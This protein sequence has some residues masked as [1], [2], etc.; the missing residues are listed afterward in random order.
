[1]LAAYWFGSTKVMLV[2]ALGLL[3]WLMLR[4]VFFHNKI[5]PVD[6]AYTLYGLLYIRLWLSGHAGPCAAA[7]WLPSWGQ[8]LRRRHVGTGAVLRLSPHLFDLGPA[9]LLPLPSAR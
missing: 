7:L 6:S 4:T 5:K 2:L 9:I 1:M 8:Q 3:F